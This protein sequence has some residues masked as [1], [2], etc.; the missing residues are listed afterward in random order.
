[1]LKFRQGS[2]YNTIDQLFSEDSQMMYGEQELNDT[3]L[4]YA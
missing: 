1:M 3:D 4:G 2:P